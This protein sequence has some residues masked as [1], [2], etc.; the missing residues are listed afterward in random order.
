[1]N[2]FVTEESLSAHL[3][4]HQVKN[5]QTKKAFTMFPPLPNQA[6]SQAPSQVGT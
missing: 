4:L 6:G 2:R 3:S 5:K 1:M